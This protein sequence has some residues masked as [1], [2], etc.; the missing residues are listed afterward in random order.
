M[1]RTNALPVL[2]QSCWNKTDK[3]GANEAVFISYWRSLE[4]VHRFAHSNKTHREA[5]KWWDST[6]KRHNYIGFMHEVYE[7]PAGAWEGVYINFQPTLLGATTYLKRDGKLVGGEVKPQYIS[8][9]VDATRGPMRTSNNRR[10]VNDPK[11]ILND[12]LAKNAYI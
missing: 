6:L 1:M 5:W 11:E 10:G 2:G 3:N 7:A 9:L 4:D 8:P 12:M